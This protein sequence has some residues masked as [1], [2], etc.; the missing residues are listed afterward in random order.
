MSPQTLSD[1]R[2]GKKRDR[3]QAALDEIRGMTAGDAKATLQQAGWSVAVAKDRLRASKGP[4]KGGGHAPEVP[5]VPADDA[6]IEAMLARIHKTRK[7]SASDAPWASWGHPHHCFFKWLQAREG[8]VS[9]Y[10]S[11][12]PTQPAAR[13][14]ADVCKPSVRA[15]GVCKPACPVVQYHGKQ[16]AYDAIKTKVKA[17]SAQ[18]PPDGSTWLWFIVA[19]ATVTKAP[20]YP[21]QPPSF[22]ASITGD[23]FQVGWCKGEPKPGMNAR[24]DV[25]L[26]QADSIGCMLNGKVNEYGRDR[27]GV[28]PGFR[29]QWTYADSAW[30]VKGEAARRT[31]STTWDETRQ[32]DRWAISVEMKREPPLSE[33]KHGADDQ[34][35]EEGTYIIIA[36]QVATKLNKNQ[37][38]TAM[39][40]TQFRIPDGSK[41]NEVKTGI[42]RQQMHQLRPTLDKSPLGSWLVKK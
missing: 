33:S 9:Q 37:Y 28:P 10:K 32:D 19:D 6:A 14:P 36:S 39:E 25:K 41:K 27:G 15:A 16:F 40:G 7:L 29:H 23:K 22:R 17:S 21:G 34:V 35:T 30:Q 42:L 31:S 24:E 13:R 20:M 12:P 2:L 4:S 3:E 5:E 38:K 26:R 8:A 11:A 18:G 1:E